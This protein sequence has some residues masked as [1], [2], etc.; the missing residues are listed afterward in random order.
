MNLNTNRLILNFLFS[1][2][3]ILPIGCASHHIPKAEIVEFNG[4]QKADNKISMKIINVQDN[5]EEKNFGNY[6]AGKMVGDLKI[7]TDSAVEMTKK[8]LEEKGVFFSDE[9]SKII[10]FSITDV[11]VDTV[12]VPWVAALARC[13]ITLNVETGE[14]YTQTYEASNKDLNPPWA[15]NKAM[16]D[17]VGAFLNDK[18]ILDYINAQ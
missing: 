9:S 18:N 10:N 16:K 12:G 6:G 3:F 7:W 14:G 1:L 4:I 8:S 5:S 2:I 11:K 17:V 15:S 13:K